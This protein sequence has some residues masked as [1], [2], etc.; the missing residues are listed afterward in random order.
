MVRRYSE[1]PEEE[2]IDYLGEVFHPAREAVPG[3]YSPD[4]PRRVSP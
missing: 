2:L 4:L 1:G 3:R